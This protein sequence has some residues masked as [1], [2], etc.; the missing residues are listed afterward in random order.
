M[1]LI[2]YKDKVILI[3]PTGAIANNISGNT[4]YT[5]LGIS[6]AKTQKLSISLCI[7]KLQARKTIIIIDKISII[8][9]SILSKINK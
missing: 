8:D 6:F 2:L 5:A 9:L 3:A 7:T 1:D 4:Y